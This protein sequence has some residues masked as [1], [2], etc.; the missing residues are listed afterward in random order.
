MFDLLFLNIIFST[1][2]I[3]KFSDYNPIQIYIYKALGENNQMI[4][5]S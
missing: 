5:Q 2:K 4:I 3:F 1:I